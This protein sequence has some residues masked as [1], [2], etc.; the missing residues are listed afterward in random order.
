MDEFVK[1]HNAKKIDET[2]NA[3]RKNGFGARFFSTKQEVADF[4]V[5]VAQDC[6]T[7]GIAGTHTVRA[8]G[9]LPMLE[10]AG[11]TIYDHWKFTPG[12]PEELDC[13][14]KQMTSDLFLSSA[15]A[16]TMTGEIVNKDGAGNRINAMTF[17]PGK[18]IIV[19]G[20]NKITVDLD[21]ALQRIESTAGPIR[22]MSLKRKT[23]CAATGYCVDCDSPERICRITSIMHRQPMMSKITVIIID[24]DLGY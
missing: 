14:K 15:N 21:D 2:I 7:V 17:G 6:N 24:K 16:I 5:E 23:P 11:K 18:T 22:A 12:T 3:L 8:L 19:V 20:K 10:S 13:R 4:I 1:L 9:V